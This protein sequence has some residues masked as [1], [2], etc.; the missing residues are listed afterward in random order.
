MAASIFL[1]CFI[2]NE[3]LYES[4]TMYIYPSPHIYI[5]YIRYYTY[6][7]ACNIRVYIRIW[8][9]CIHTVSYLGTVFCIHI[10]RNSAPNGVPARVPILTYSFLY[11]TLFELVCVCVCIVFYTLLFVIDLSVCMC[12]YRRARR[13]CD[14]YTSHSHHS[15]I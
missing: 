12:E 10:H 3:P 11:T 14:A 9:M 13:I 5:L 15:T 6:S 2:S 8:C 1:I 7:V 4:G